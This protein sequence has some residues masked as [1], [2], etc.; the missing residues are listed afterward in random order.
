MRDEKKMCSMG[1]ILWALYIHVFPSHLQDL[2]QTLFR[3]VRASLGLPSVSTK[4]V[5]QSLRKDDLNSHCAAMGLFWE[6]LLLKWRA[7]VGCAL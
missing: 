2:G 7:V 1:G 6:S 5:L 4:G 3:R